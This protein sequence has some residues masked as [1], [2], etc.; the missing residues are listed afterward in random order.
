MTKPT[1]QLYTKS[2]GDEEP[3]AFYIVLRWDDR[4]NNDA[5]RESHINV[6]AD[7]AESK[8]AEFRDNDQVQ[9]GSFHIIRRY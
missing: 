1:C 6:C 8:K 4:S 2:H 3:A 9:R 5:R 7:C